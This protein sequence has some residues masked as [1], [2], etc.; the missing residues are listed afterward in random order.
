MGFLR[1]SNK[2]GEEKG[3]VFFVTTIQKREEIFAKS[4]NSKDGPVYDPAKK[5]E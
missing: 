5:L 4:E 3:T 1:A 2:A